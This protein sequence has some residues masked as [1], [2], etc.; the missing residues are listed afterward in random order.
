MKAKD[1]SI[2][3]TC[4]V[5]LIACVLMWL[6]ARKNAQTATYLQE[7][8]DA[9]QS[10]QRVSREQHQYLLD[11]LESTGDLLLQERDLPSDTSPQKLVEILAKDKP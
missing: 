9:H 4:V 8:S 1:V 11:E 5:T 3:F 2:L 6:T 10:V 7:W